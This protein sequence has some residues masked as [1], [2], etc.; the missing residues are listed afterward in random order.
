M[1]TDNQFGRAVDVQVRDH[2]ASLADWAV[3]SITSSAGRRRW[4]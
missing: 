2:D 4:S 3:Y 1:S